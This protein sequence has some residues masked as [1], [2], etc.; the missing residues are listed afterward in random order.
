MDGARATW[1]ELA[2]RIEASF[3]AAGT[4]A[5]LN[6]AAD[7]ARADLDRLKAH[8]P[9]L[10]DPLRAAWIAR[11]DEIAAPSDARDHPL[12]RA[13]L[14]HFPDATIDA[15]RPIPRPQPAEPA[16]AIRDAAE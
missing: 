12:V 4:L 10:V 3:A 15:V 5:D 9:S 7:R 1:A 16:N 14:A 8:A 13:V 11:R 6:R 2:E